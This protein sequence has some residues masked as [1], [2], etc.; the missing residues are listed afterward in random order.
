MGDMRII[1]SPADFATFAYPVDPII[2]LLDSILSIWPQEDA[3][4]FHYA[5]TLPLRALPERIAEG[6]CVGGTMIFPI[7]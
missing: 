5:V 7:P 4:N 2:D 6:F 1:R 3:P